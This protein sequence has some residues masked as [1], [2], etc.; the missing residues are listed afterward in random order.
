MEILMPVKITTITTRA[1][2]SIAWPGENY[3]PSANNLFPSRLN[4]DYTVLATLSDDNLIMTKTVL[5]T[6]KEKYFEVISSGNNADLENYVN[7]TVVE[8]ITSV[9]TIETV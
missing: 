2:T 3:T 7:T 1:N 9:R 6:N 4:I 8:G 5:W